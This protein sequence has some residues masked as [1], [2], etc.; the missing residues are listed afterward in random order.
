M[1]EEIEIVAL[2]WINC[3]ALQVDARSEKTGPFRMFIDGENLFKALAQSMKT[4]DQIYLEHFNA[5]YNGENIF[6]EA[7][8]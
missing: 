8:E 4:C 7:G 6:E 2:E 5:K 1:G 3:S